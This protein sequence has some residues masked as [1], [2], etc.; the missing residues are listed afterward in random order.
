M[1]RNA[2]V[3]VRHSVASALT[4]DDLHAFDS[5][6]VCFLMPCV[7]VHTKAECP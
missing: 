7:P 5:G 4:D 1:D 3:L 2:I 6:L